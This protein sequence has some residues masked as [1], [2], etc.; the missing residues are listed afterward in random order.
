MIKWISCRERDPD[1]QVLRD[2]GAAMRQE[3][4]FQRNVTAYHHSVATQF[5]F[6]QQ[7]LVKHQGKSTFS[8]YALVSTQ[9]F[10]IKVKDLRRILFFDELGSN[11]QM[12]VVKQVVGVEKTHIIAGR[13]LYTKVP[14]GPALFIHLGEITNSII[15]DTFNNRARIVRTSVIDY[16]HFEIPI[17]LA[18]RG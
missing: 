12:V 3:R 7:S 17:A 6:F 4:V 8:G 13:L 14:R 16:D 15:F 10:I 5:L 1:I 2:D 11:R 18:Q 9:I